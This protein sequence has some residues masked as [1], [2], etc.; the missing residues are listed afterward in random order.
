MNDILEDSTNFKKPI[1]QVKP[2]KS[3]Q[4]LFHE[5]QQEQKRQEHKLNEDENEASDNSF[6]IKKRKRGNMYIIFGINKADDIFYFFLIR[7]KT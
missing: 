4:Q 5:K 2:I 1:A 6:E 7:T 3:R